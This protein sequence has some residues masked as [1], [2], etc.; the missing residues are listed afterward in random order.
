MADPF[1]KLAST[2]RDRTRS[3]AFAPNS[4]RRARKQQDDEKKMAADARDIE[5]ARKVRE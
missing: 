2:A 3:G 1:P 4:P 5:T